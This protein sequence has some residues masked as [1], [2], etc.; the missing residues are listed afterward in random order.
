[1]SERNCYPQSE[2]QKEQLYDCARSLKHEVTL[3]RIRNRLEYTR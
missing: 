2:D 3:V 1:M